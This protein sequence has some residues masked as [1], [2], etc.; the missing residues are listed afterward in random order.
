M[1]HRTPITQV[2]LLVTLAIAIIACDAPDATP[3]PLYYPDTIPTVAPTATPHP[4]LPPTATPTPPPTSTPKP[5]PAPTATAAPRPT[6]T[7]TPPPTEPTA[8]IPA[9][10]PTPLDQKALDAQLN[11]DEKACVTGVTNGQPFEVFFAADDTPP[12]T[13]VAFLD[14]LEPDTWDQLLAKH[15]HP[16][17]GNA[18]F[19][20]CVMSALVVIEELETKPPDVA[21]FEQGMDLIGKG[22]GAIFMSAALCAA[23]HDPSMMEE[24]K[25]ERQDGM[26]C[27]AEQL[28]DAPQVVRELIYDEDTLNARIAAA[29]AECQAQGYEV[30]D[31]EAW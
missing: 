25:I 21:T 18:D 16:S 30:P 8:T 11:P 27:Y 20:Y 7:P 3:P 28:G 29:T 17:E 13:M 15:S 12:S 22:I 5:T 14:C 26:R 2:L 1:I 19:Q 9:A 4:T 31:L 24:M 10:E 6:A 23:I